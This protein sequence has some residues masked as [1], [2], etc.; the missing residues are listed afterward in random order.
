MRSEVRNQ[1]AARNVIALIKLEG[2]FKHVLTKPHAREGVK[3]AFVEVVCDATTVLNFTK[4]VMY[5]DPRHTLRGG[6]KEK[7]LISNMV[8]IMKPLFA[9]LN[10]YT[11]CSRKREFE[12]SMVKNN[13]D[14]TW[15]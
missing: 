9:Y 7:R 1:R 8:C 3:Q 2:I 12:K 14:V 6:R 5:R 15:A 10:N 13:E 4:H 11:V